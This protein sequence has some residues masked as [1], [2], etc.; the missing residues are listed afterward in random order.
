MD[1]QTRILIAK[2]MAGIQEECH[3][4]HEWQKLGRYV[5]HGEKHLFSCFIWVP[6]PR[7]KGEPKDSLHAEQNGFIYTNAYFFGRSQTE[8]RY[9]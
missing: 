1:N 7:K 6:S 8:R 2:S 4:Y 5:R 9:R 3:T